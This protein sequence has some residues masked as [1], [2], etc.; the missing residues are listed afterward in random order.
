MNLELPV[1]RQ[2]L[3]QWLGRGQ[4]ASE[5]ESRV[6]TL[7]RLAWAVA[8]LVMV[9][10]GV[11]AMRRE[12]W[13]DAA[14]LCGVGVGLWLAHMGVRHFPPRAIL[15]T[16]RLDLRRW[17]LGSALALGTVGLAVWRWRVLELRAVTN[18]DWLWYLGTIGLMVAAGAVLEPWRPIRCRPRLGRAGWGWLALFGA[19]LLVRL[20]WLDHLPFGVWYDEA[21]NGLE[22]LRILNEPAYRPIYTD[23]VNSTGHYLWLLAGAIQVWGATP[24]ALRV[25]SALLGAA[26]AAAAFWVGDELHGRTVAWVWA[27]L[28]AVARWSITFSRIGMYNMATP[29]FELLALGFLVRGMRRGS[30]LD[31]TLAGVSIGL[32]LCFYSAYQLFLGVLG[33]FVLV[34]AWQERCQWR[35]LWFGLVVTGVAVAIVIAPVAK[36]ALERPDSYF[37][38]VQTTS[39]FSGKA[40]EERL[41]ALWSNVRKH[42][43][44]FHV[45]G[46]PNGR[47][48][49]PGEPMLDWVTGGLMIVGLGLCLRKFRS[50]LFLIV[51][52]WIG[53]GL[54]GG[55]FSLDFEAPQSLRS[56]GALPAVL[57]C[58]AL[59]TAQLLDEWRT[60]PGRWTPAVGGWLVG[61]GLLMPMA[62]LNLHTYFVRQA[63]DFAAWNAHST[64]ETLAAGLIRGADPNTISYVIS[65]FDGHPTV[66]FLARGQSYQRVETNATLPLLRETSGTI[67]LL[68]DAEREELFREAQRL[69]ATGQFEEIHPPFG[70]PVV[71]Y[72]TVLDSPTLAS[73]QGLAGTYRPVDSDEPEQVRKESVIDFSWPISA[74]VPLPFEAE[75]RGI[76]AVNVYGPYQFFVQAPGQVT[77]WIGESVIL[78]G[79]AGATGGLAASLMLARGHHTVRLQ[80]EGGEGVVRLAWQPPDGPP[81]TIPPWALYVPPVRSNGL[82]GSYYA[83]D[84]WS[85]TPAFAQIDPNLAMYFHVPTLVRPY[86][87]IWKGKIAIPEDGSY[88]FALQSIDESQLL[89]DEV[90]IV[91]SRVANEMVHSQLTLEAGLHDIEVRY[92]DR[93]NHTY[94]KLLWTPPGANEA[95]RP[96][97]TDLLFPPQ[98]RYDS[99]DVSDLARFLEGGAERTPI[100]V[101][102]RLDPAVAEVIADGIAAPRGVAVIG[103]QVFVAE[104]GSRRVVVVE[105]ATGTVST[106][107]LGGVNLEEPFDLAAVAG[108][109]YIQDA[110]SGALV[111]Y[112]P[113]TGETSRSPVDPTYIVRSRGVGAGL[114]DTIW[115]ANTPGQRVVEV[116]PDGSVMRDL[117]LPAVATQGREMQPVDVAA[118][119][120]GTIYVT[121][122]ANHILY[123]FSVAGYLLS[124]QA[125]P[126]ANA[127]DSSHLAVDDEGRVLM[128]EPEAGR[129]VR[130]SAAG[131]VERAWSVRT[132]AAPD[133][134]PIGIAVDEAGAIWVADA[135]GGRILRL[136]PEGE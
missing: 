50:P 107:T 72:R 70:G 91:T 47:H 41:P 10:A 102:E 8:A 71:L 45:H 61:V 5:P 28:A 30:V 86:T 85:G 14:A 84:S 77:L 96:V 48:N 25:I 31:Y 21:A 11:G 97:P 76:L 101:R 7:R 62:V 43:L 100:V 108:K 49:L 27:V 123:Q 125:I 66:R 44:M 128:T 135:Q 109:L 133:A 4:Q 58:A 126:V 40:P 64:P 120:D 78:E 2:R 105:R 115:L 36:Y 82:L 24:E 73:I 83:N 67:Q 106:L 33:I 63:N 13:W 69:Y 51:P 12:L 112:D 98:A 119:P 1:H 129:V 113:A 93:T 17:W 88:G 37:S 39:L 104:T 42:L 29:L 127:M 15:G 87:V 75:W 68:L 131:S 9:F 52:V 134:K 111:V 118:L 34:V 117:T 57:L 130:L 65:L 59:P 16:A 132:S 114:E 55:I 26:T 136:V 95:F 18:A 35:N 116:N 38:R 94:I 19:A 81:E 22:A 80:A 53:I 92:A 23:G 3:W 99:V 46:D 54:V 79:D 124:S 60:G 103:D 89:I 32:G 6:P 121:D 122:V 74:P 56:I 90:E 20:L 110:G